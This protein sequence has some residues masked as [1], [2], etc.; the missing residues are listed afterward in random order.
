MDGRN[1]ESW[2][3]SPLVCFP[4]V[5]PAGILVD[6]VFVFVPFAV[7]VLLAD[8]DGPGVFTLVVCATRSRNRRS[9][10]GKQKRTC[11]MM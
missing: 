6:G 8:P 9:R 4:R 3:T 5:V 2:A 11:I 7:P 1:V 10:L